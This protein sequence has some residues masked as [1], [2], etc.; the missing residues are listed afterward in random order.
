MSQDVTIDR[1][2]VTTLS[3][4]DL[5]LR[6]ADAG[7]LRGYF[8]R[9][10]GEDSVLFHNHTPEAG[11]RYDYS[12]VQYKVIEG[13]PM[14]V[15]VA[16][17]ADLVLQAFLGV[18]EIDLGGSRVSVSSKELM[19]HRVPAGVIEELRE[20]R[21]VTPLFAFNQV[22]YAEYKSLNGVERDDWIRKKLTNHIVTALRGIGCAVTPERPILLSARL[23]PK[24]VQFKNRPMQMYTGDFTAN[25]AFPDLLGI[26]KST[27]KGFG[28]VRTS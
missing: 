4:P 27:S 21:L 12:L 24:L 18:E 8:A 19:S 2:P 11:F 9:A 13:V 10:F 3:F 26:G 23:Q 6:G 22:N 7:K 14:V 15:G 28:V 1:I 25:I 5:R 20:Y 17:G 16:A